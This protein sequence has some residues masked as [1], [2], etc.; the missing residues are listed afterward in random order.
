DGRLRLGDHIVCVQDFNVRG[1]GP[2]Q[3]A[4]VLRHTI[5]AKL[6]AT[7][8][9]PEEDG[10]G[11]EEGSTVFRRLNSDSSPEKAV[12]NNASE[13]TLT[14]KSIPSVPVRLIVA[15][16]ALA[17]PNDLSDIYIEQQ[18]RMAEQQVMDAIGVVPTEQLDEYLEALLNTSLSSQPL[19]DGNQPIGLTVSATQIDPLSEHGE[20]CDEEPYLKKSSSI[21]TNIAACKTVRGWPTKENNESTSEEEP[22]STAYLP[23]E[24]SDLGALAEPDSYDELISK[25]HCPSSPMLTRENA[26]DR[27]ENIGSISPLEKT[28]GLA[29]T[30][31]EQLSVILERPKDEGLGLTVVGYVYRDPAKSKLHLGGEYTSGIF[32]QSLATN[33]VAD[34]CGQ[35]RK[36][37]QIIQ[38]GDSFENSTAVTGPTIALTSHHSNE[39]M[40]TCENS[41]PS[42]VCSRSSC[43]TIASHVRCTEFRTWHGQ[44]QESTRIPLYHTSLGAATAD[45]PDPHEVGPGFGTLAGPT[46]RRDLIGQQSGLNSHSRPSIGQMPIANGAS[47]TRQ[48]L[49]KVITA[50]VTYAKRSVN[51]CPR[52]VNTY[53]KC[54]TNSA[55]IPM[56]LRQTDTLL[57]VFRQDANFIES[58][59]IVELT[60]CLEHP[61][62]CNQMSSTV[63]PPVLGPEETLHNLDRIKDF[64][65]SGDNHN[66]NSSASV[67]R[68]GMQYAEK[69]RKT[70]PSLSSYLDFPVEQEVDFYK[71]P[72]RIHRN[73]LLCKQTSQSSP[74]NRVIGGR[75][76][77]PS[78]IY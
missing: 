62:T 26:E 74:S 42:S 53:Q 67:E 27:K 63:E 30:D 21:S 13:L 29:S 9:N 2:D 60:E 5:S 46:S 22:V 23:I 36:N 78:I 40:F 28:S 6:L 37:D 64:D 12:L 1:F 69:R 7:G 18:R 39:K 76:T 35:I 54:K 58:P 61:S 17:D 65:S 25:L 57:R 33:S 41:H 68:F 11:A 45:K 31:F 70:V 3:V 20:L 14:E 4:T 51:A 16:S 75:I 24:K 38:V 49:Q 59:M 15:R 19:T 55:A 8:L 73:L 34:K 47:R 71:F 44:K 56:H 43:N 32:V 48:N 77:D 50:Y 10:S 52:L 72:T 66:A